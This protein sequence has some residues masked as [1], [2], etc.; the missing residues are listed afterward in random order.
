MNDSNDDLVDDN[1]DGDIDFSVLILQVPIHKSD[2]W[3][4]D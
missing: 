4:I 3:L 1:N 2:D